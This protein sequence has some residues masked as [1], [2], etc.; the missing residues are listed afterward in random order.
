MFAFLKNCMKK[1]KALSH[2]GQEE[3]REEVSEPV[4]HPSSRPLKVHLLGD[5]F[6]PTLTYHLLRLILKN[7]TK[8]KQ[9][10][11]QRSGHGSRLN[12]F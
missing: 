4:P 2:A 7:P 8:Q 5:N 9:N 12:C 6:L 3:V 10:S 11:N 1:K